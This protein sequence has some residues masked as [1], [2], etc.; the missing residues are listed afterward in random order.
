MEQA[1]REAIQRMKAENASE[2]SIQAARRENRVN[3]QKL[4]LERIAQQRIQMTLDQAQAQLLRNE[5]NARQQLAQQ[6][7]IIQQQS[8]QL[9]QL[10]QH[11][12]ASTVAAVQHQYDISKLLGKSNQV[13][14]QAAA[15][16]AAAAKPPEKPPEEP[17]DKSPRKKKLKENTSRTTR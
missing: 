16:A 11:A 13:D 15:Q 4:G 9:E 8:M 5:E 7:A 1:Q 14:Q 10:R 2:A 17:Q 6:S 3:Q 12:E